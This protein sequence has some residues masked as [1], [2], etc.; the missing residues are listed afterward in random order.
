LVVYFCLEIIFESIIYSSLGTDKGEGW[1]EQR[2]GQQLST[3]FH[4]FSF[5]DSDRNNEPEKPLWNGWLGMEK[6]RRK[7][8]LRDEQTEKRQVFGMSR[9]HEAYFLSLLILN[10]Q[11]HCDEAVL[12]SDSSEEALLRRVWTRSGV[13]HSDNEQ[14]VLTAS[15]LARNTLQFEC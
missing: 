12:V 6:I 3:S 5:D 7:V 11:D 1:E 13:L 4:L 8:S 15:I 10:S 9:C 2:D 14:P